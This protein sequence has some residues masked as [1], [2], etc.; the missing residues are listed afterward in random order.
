M[1]SKESYTF[2]TL[3]VGWEE[4]AKWETGQLWLKEFAYV[5][6]KE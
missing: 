4:K 2:I 1:V 3:A 5:S 6:L